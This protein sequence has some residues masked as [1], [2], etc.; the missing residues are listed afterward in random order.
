ML[1]NQSTAQTPTQQAR[2]T[3]IQERSVR[4]GD[5]IV[6]NGYHV[7]RSLLQARFADRGYR[8]HETKQISVPSLLK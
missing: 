6:V 3:S 7:N 1:E 4:I 8:V 5:V 2:T